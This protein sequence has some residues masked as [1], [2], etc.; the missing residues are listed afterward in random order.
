M[1]TP[2]FTKLGSTLIA[3]DKVLA[4]RPSTGTRFNTLEVTFDTGQILS[5]VDS[6]PRCCYSVFLLGGRRDSSVFN[7]RAVCGRNE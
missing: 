2:T 4:I 5:I 6:D 7:A 1:S 3:R